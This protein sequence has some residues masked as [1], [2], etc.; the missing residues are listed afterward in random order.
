MREAP[1]SK[2]SFRLAEPADSGL[3]QQ[4]SSEAYVPA[5]EQIIGA[6]PKPAYEDY[7]PRISDGLVWLLEDDGYTSGVLV[8]EVQALYLLVY[9]IAVRPSCQGRGY[10]R[11]LLEFAE[12]Q[13]RNRNLS[14]IR[15]YTNTKMASN[16]RLY[17]ACGFQ[18]FGKRPHPSREGESLVDMSKC[19]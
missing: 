13:A 7:R 2:L 12:Q 5:Y 8:V 18:E 17:V 1:Q 10:G 16:V 9:S 15:L 6:V 11:A 3:V 14:E 19:L 4:I